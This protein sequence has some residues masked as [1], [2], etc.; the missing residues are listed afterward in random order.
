MNV[1]IKFEADILLTE[2]LG[3]FIVV[4]ADHKVTGL[5]LNSADVLA[6]Y[7]FF[8]LSGSQC[9]GLVFAEDAINKGAVAVVYDPAD[10]PVNVIENSRF[11]GWIALP[12]LA[13][14]LGTIAARFYGDPA[15]QIKVIGI[16]G[17]N[18]KTSCSQFLGQ[19]LDACGIIGTLGWGQWGNLKPTINT[20]PDALTLQKTLLEMQSMQLDSVAMEVSSHGLAQAR[21][22]GIGFDG[23]VITNISRDHL[24]YHG[25]MEAYISAKTRLLQTPGLQYTVINL[26]SDYSECIISEIPKGVAVWAISQHGR[27]LDSG[28]TL[29]AEAV[30]CNQDGVQFDLLWQQQRLRASAPIYG[31]F[32]VEN[33]LIVLAVLLANG[34]AIEQAIERIRQV[35]A[36]PGRM[37]S[38][39]LGKATAQVFIDYAHTPDALQSVLSS[40]R[41]YCQEK[42][43]VVFGCG[44]DRDQGKRALMGGIAE[45]YADHVVITDDNP[46]SENP[47]AIV[48]DILSGCNRESTQII[49][50]R[51]LAI[52]TTLLKA[53]PD[54]CVVIAGK[55]H[56]TYQE[57][58]GQRNYFSDRKLLKEMKLAYSEA[59]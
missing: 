21:V 15:E 8:A 44:G 20:T 54:D 6:G 34:C 3:E 31:E 52:R 22:N 23:A 49:H 2:L 4:E 56:E 28:N 18:G 32:N 9:H 7:V 37:E 5:A 27:R 45:Q 16:T 35:Q 41:A 25:S 39:R 57:V 46:R 26:D 24:D 1:A 48:S 36:I 29:Q 55:G 42:L 13:E 30:C 50:D 33:L 59:L 12:G 11:E 10:A 53:E 51:E 43:W 47:E 40:A 19:T 58:A 14:K 17:T 38:F